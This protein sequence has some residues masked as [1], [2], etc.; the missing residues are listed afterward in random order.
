MRV[1]IRSGLGIRSAMLIDSC[2]VPGSAS[3]VLLI[4][5]S[6]RCSMDKWWALSTRTF[7]VTIALPFV[8]RW[9]WGDRCT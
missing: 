4:D 1:A 8:R 3:A 6:R 2:R 5:A 9:S 7:T